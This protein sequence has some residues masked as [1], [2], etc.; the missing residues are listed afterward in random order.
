[1]R[2]SFLFIFLT[3]F[4]IQSMNAIIMTG[5]GLDTG[6]GFIKWEQL[7]NLPRQVQTLQRLYLASAAVAVGIIVYRYWDKIT[8]KTEVVNEDNSVLQII[9]KK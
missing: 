5:A 9:E 6:H 3:F 1:M 2:Y 8:A 7:V 4:N